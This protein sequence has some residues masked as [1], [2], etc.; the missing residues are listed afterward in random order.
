MKFK[1]VIFDLDGTLI[2]SKEDLAMATNTTLQEEGFRTWPVESYGLF[3]GKGIR[4]LV[5][6]ALPEDRRDET[7]VE[8][9]REKT[10]SYYSEHY[11]VR[12]RMY[13]QIPEMLSCLV[14]VGVKLCVLSNKPHEMTEKI[15]T[16]PFSSWPFVHVI[17]A[18]ERFPM[19]P[20]PEAVLY[21]C[22]EMKLGVE[23]VLY[24]GDSDVDMLTA[25][26]AG[27][28]PLGVTWGFRSRDELIEAGAWKLA[29]KA[30]DI[31][32]IAIGEGINN[33]NRK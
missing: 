5:W 24:V 22:R 19:K 20:D 15:M 2:D 1:A 16:G 3:L 4:N 14:S 13:P 25:R 23:D 6:N 29:D 21:M 12:T 31:A 30:M 17:G 7:T 27:V 32:S 8:R 26:N 10:L 33:F 11:W 18:G 28:K 9:C